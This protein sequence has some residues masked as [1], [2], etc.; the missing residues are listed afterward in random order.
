MGDSFVILT[1]ESLKAT[2]IEGLSLLVVDSRDAWK[3]IYIYIYIYI[4]G[5]SSEKVQIKFENRI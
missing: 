3:S 1:W 4:Y 5:Q 2:W